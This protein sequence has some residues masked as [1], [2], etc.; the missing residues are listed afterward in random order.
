[1]LFGE[2]RL[3]VREFWWLEQ[4]SRPYILGGVWAFPGHK[5]HRGVNFSEFFNLSF[6]DPEGGFGLFVKAGVCVKVS[7]EREGKIFLLDLSSSRW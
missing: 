1:L 7:K 2:L 4:V 5:L 3:C 6:L